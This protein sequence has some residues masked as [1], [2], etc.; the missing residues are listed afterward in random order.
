VGYCTDG[1]KFMCED[2]L[3]AHAK[4]RESSLHKVTASFAMKLYLPQKELG[5]KSSTGL[6]CPEH[7]GMELILFC[8]SCDKLICRDCALTGHSIHKYCYCKE[9]ASKYRPF[10]EKQI[11]TM[12]LKQQE[13]AQFASHIKQL[14]SNVD[15]KCIDAA[16]ELKT[17]FNYLHQMLVE[18]ESTLLK[19]LDG[20][21]KMKSDQLAGHFNAL[22][23]Q[24][25]ALQ[26]ECVTTENFLQ[27]ETELLRQKARLSQKMSLL[28]NYQ[29]TQPARDLR[30][31]NRF[32][33]AQ[34]LQ[35]FIANFGNVQVSEAE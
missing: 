7:Q 21:R 26:I 35:Q 11:L 4:G 24:F 23:Q 14:A 15:K 20:L 13:V 18:R 32:D 9:A 17:C 1:C 33:G 34:E 29:Y 28:C 30:V 12:K 27:S 2:H 3:K 16:M 10:I 8:E 6:Y 25:Q 31:M 19:G 22:E 5:M